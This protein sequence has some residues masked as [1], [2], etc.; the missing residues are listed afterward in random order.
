MQVDRTKFL[1]LVTLIAASACGPSRHAH[2]ARDLDDDDADEL[3]DDVRAD[4]ARSSRSRPE[5]APP[6]PEPTESGP[7]E[8]PGP[9]SPADAP[10]DWSKVDL[11][12]EP[13]PAD[14]TSPAEKQARAR[15]DEYLIGPCREGFTVPSFCSN[16]LS[17]IEPP[18]YDAYF[19]CAKPAVAAKARVDPPACATA[20]ATCQKTTN[21]CNAAQNELGICEERA[22]AAC[23]K[24]PW[25]Q[26]QS[27][28]W[29]AC[30]K[31]GVKGPE[32]E[33]TCGA[34][35][36]LLRECRD[37]VRERGCTKETD[38]LAACEHQQE[39]DC[40][41]EP[42]CEQKVMKACQAAE[43]VFEKCA[44]KAK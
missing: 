17:D 15:C 39:K 20:A 2:S 16:H 10:P 41:L 35:G 14:E 27:A 8:R 21:R 5:P 18:K 40:T 3:L 38:V 28:C 7:I 11:A 26:K 22:D 25:V 4:Q 33:K 30:G 1:A 24:T 32:C 19:T 9:A 44:A 36:R 37:K 29:T 31:S 23:A 6:R 12:S 42:A 13:A 43:D 34:S